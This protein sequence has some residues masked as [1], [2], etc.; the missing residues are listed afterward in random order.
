[1]SNLLTWLTAAAIAATPAVGAAQQNKSDAKGDK[2]AN[3]RNWMITAQR[4]YTAAGD[5][6]EKGEVVVADGKIRAVA[7]G[8]GGDLQAYAVTPGLVDLSIRIDKGFLSVEQSNE[9]TPQVRALESLDL[10]DEDWK[11]AA[12]G[13]VTTAMLNVPDRN[14]IGGQSVVL[15]TGGERSAEARIVKR[16]AVLYGAIGSAPS[17]MNHPAFGRPEDFYSRR[18]TTRMGVEWE[19][20]KALFEAAMAREDSKRAKPGDAELQ[21]A[22]DGRLPLMIEAWAT[23]D[24][25]TTVFLVEEAAR[26]GWGRP[27]LIVDAA[28]EAWREPQ[29]LVRVG[30]SVVLPPFVAEGRTRDGAFFALETAARLEALGVPVALS[31]HN[32]SSL[33]SRLCYQP[34]YAMRGGMSFADAL[35]AV[36][37][38]PARM[39]G[40]D[41]RVGTLE[42]GKDAD[43]VLWSGEP[44]QPSSMVIGVLIDGRLVVDP[45][46]QAPSNQPNK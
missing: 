34:G 41:S 44:F 9:I 13:G 25:R 3:R 26:E 20:R 32:A 24:I 8:G 11:R 29:L 35:E 37:I 27:R 22:L 19:W 38:N 6:I 7:K 2:D 5:P 17:S 12:R 40:V 4:V 45:R 36:T 21:S 23:Q 33:E 15:K 43:L 46:S 31:G 16:D 14:V 39:V 42:A 30:A 10:F 18:P 28:A 1:M